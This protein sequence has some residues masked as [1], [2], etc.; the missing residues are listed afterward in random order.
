MPRSGESAG[1]L[2]VATLA[3]PLSPAL[4]RAETQ[5]PTPSAPIRAMPLSSPAGLAAV[6]MKPKK[7]LP[8]GSTVI[9]VLMKTLAS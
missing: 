6:T 2:L 1:A 5:L 9:G 8:S 3:T 7:T 4:M